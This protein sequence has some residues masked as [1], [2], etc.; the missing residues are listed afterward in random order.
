MKKIFFLALASVLTFGAVAYAAGNRNQQ[1]KTCTACP[2][3]V[4]TPACM[5]ACGGS[6]CSKAK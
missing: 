4:C 1:P 6:C 5:A 2:D 3:K